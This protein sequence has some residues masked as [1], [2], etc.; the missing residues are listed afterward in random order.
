MVEVI[1]Q[2]AVDLFPSCRFISFFCHRQDFSR[3]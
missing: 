2:M 3:I 1:S